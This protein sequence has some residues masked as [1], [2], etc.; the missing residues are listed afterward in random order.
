MQQVNLTSLTLWV[1]YFAKILQQPSTVF[2]TL[3]YPAVQRA[4]G[5]QF[6][7]GPAES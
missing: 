5:W 2:M 7:T 1:F 3:Q 4:S 6:I